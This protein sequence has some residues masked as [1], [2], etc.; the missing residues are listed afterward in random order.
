MDLIHTNTIT[1]YG[2]SL[3]WQV[4]HILRTYCQSRNLIMGRMGKKQ[5]KLVQPKRSI[6][7][8]T[9][10]PIARRSRHVY[11]VRRAQIVLEDPFWIPF[12]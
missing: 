3:N 10:R 1:K 6:R 11:Y 5:R 2:R 12:Y 8:A 4:H 9:M 7:T